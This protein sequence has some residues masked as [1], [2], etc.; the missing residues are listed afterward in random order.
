MIVR[1]R[2]TNTR[3]H[4]G[5][6]PNFVVPYIGLAP[7]RTKTA[8]NGSFLIDAW[9]RANAGAVS[10][11]GGKD[12]LGGI[13]KQGDLYLRR[14]FTAGAFALIRYAKTHGTRRYMDDRWF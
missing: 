11:S 9:P 3:L 6:R 13:S 8:S 5:G 12:K 14:F 2:S 10:S 7:R 4:D 1:S